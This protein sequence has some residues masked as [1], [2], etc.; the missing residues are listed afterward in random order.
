MYLST[1]FVPQQK[2]SNDMRILKPR[3]TGAPSEPSQ[4]GGA[5]PAAA[6]APQP[7]PTAVTWPGMELLNDPISAQV[8]MSVWSADLIV[9]VPSPPGS[10]KTRLTVLLAAALSHRAGLRVGIAAQTRAQAID[11]ARRLGAVCERP[12][13]G[14]L[15]GRTDVKPDAH[16]CPIL[17]AGT[18]MWPNSGGAV[19]V[20]TKARWLFSEPSK[21]KAD[22][23]IVD[24]AYQ[25]TYADLG[26]LG[27]MAA[28]VVCVGDPGQIDP[29]VT[30]DVSRWAD[31][32]TGPHVPA[33]H[34][35]A[36]AHPSVV[37]TV[38][39]PY[40]WR[41]GPQTTHIVQTAFYPD[42]P[43]TSRRPPE[44]IAVAG[45]PLPELTHRAITVAN[46]STDTALIAAAVTRVR[47]LLD[48]AHVCTTAGARPL[49]EDDLAVVVPHV[50][51]AAA[52]RAMLAD[53]PGLLC[54]T[55]DA[56]QG[57]ERPAVVAVHP[58][59]GKRVADDFSLKTG[60]LCVMLSRHRSH[61]SLLV[62]DQT[63]AVLQ[64]SDS[65]AAGAAATVLDRL[66]ETAEF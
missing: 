21:T 65:E 27:S 45:Q 41:L 36:A 17:D 16:G 12:K 9:N 64:Q 47:D 11:I 56:L 51:Q 14:L 58:M 63:A 8:L 40:T 5:A 32:P 2:P 57:L 35:L 13:I 25:C 34:A 50:P 4:D 44:H 61:L 48:G 15:W 53:H 38:A 46:G 59:A 20:A 49:T 6:P 39:L 30:G 43:F 62:D 33:P 24:E 31:S 54:G 29:V 22:V 10:G 23:V 37:N 66:L 42:L 55:A 18:K 26:A 1:S 60:R 7:K 3:N 28:Q 52:V 19:R